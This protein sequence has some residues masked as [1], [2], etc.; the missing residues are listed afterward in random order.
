MFNSFFINTASNLNTPYKKSLSQNRNISEIV[1][2]AF[3]NFEN[4]SSIV[5][6]KKKQSVAMIFR[7][8][9]YK[10]L[11]TYSLHLHTIIKSPC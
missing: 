1:E 5:A 10:T 7:L 9:N 3:K 11:K 8:K 4:H 2:H 6:I